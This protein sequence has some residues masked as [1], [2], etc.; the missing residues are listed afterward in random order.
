MLVYDFGLLLLIALGQSDK[1]LLN[2][3]NRKSCEYRNSILGN[4]HK[5]VRRTT[6]VRL[7]ARMV[8]GRKAIRKKRALSVP[9]Y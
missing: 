7:L 5:K 1:N 9:K 2:E 6:V 8:K 4:G 3:V